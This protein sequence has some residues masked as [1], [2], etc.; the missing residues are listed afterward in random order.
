MSFSWTSSRTSRRPSHG[1][2]SFLD[3]SITNPDENNIFNF[4]LPT[5]AKSTIKKDSIAHLKFKS[6]ASRII[7]DIAEKELDENIGEIITIHPYPSSSPT[8]TSPLSANEEA[9]NNYLE[10]LKNKYTELYLSDL[11]PTNDR[12]RIRTPLS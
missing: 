4:T 11:P 12:K 6:F 1:I 3:K 10:G 9:D 5:N 7:R 8:L 2:T